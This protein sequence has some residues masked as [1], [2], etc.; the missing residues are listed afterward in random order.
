[1][2]SVIITDEKILSVYTD[3]IRDEIKS[4]GENYRQKNYVGNYYRMYIMYLSE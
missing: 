4:V 1:M 3:K 2:P